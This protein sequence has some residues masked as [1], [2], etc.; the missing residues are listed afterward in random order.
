M[1]NWKPMLES[2]VKT[3]VITALAITLAQGHF[4][5]NKGEWF[6][7]G[8]SILWAF[9]GLVYSWLSPRNKNFGIGSTTTTTPSL[10]S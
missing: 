6:A 5:T 10:Q 1:S 4:P 9:I 2:Y 3:L 7:L 8:T